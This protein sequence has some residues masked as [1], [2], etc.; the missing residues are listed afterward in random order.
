[1]IAN[2]QILGCTICWPITLESDIAST[3]MGQACAKYIIT[4]QNL[5]GTFLNYHWTHNE[6]VMIMKRS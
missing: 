2:H 1:M 5:Y 4:G 3:N 6:R